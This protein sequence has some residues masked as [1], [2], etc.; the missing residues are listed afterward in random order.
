[1]T[2]YNSRHSVQFVAIFLTI[3]TI[4]RIIK[5]VPT[6]PP[7]LYYMIWG[8][9]AVYILMH[10]YVSCRINYSYL[11]F[12][13]ICVISIIGNDIDPKYN[14]GLRFI[15]FLLIVCSIGPI[16][17][18]D[19][20]Y[21][22]RQKCFH[23]VLMGMTIISVIS[24]LIYC[25]LP[26]LMLTERGNLYGGITI[27]SMQMGP[28]AGLSTVYMIHMILNRHKGQGNKKL[29]FYWVCLVLSLFSCILAGSRSAILAMIV[30]VSIYIWRYYRN[31]ILQFIKIIVCFV[32]IMAISTPLWW[33][34]T[35]TVQAKMELSEKKGGFITSRS[36]A[37]EARLNEFV[38][39]P[40]I[41]CGFATVVGSF[42]ERGNE[43]MV[44]PGNGWLFVLSTT[45]IVTFVIFLV[46]YIHYLFFLLK[47]ST[48]ESILLGS[49]LIFWGIHINAEAYTLSSGTF[50][51]YFLW[52]SLGY[53]YS[54]INKC[55]L[56]KLAY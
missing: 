20:L 17:D 19:W 31:N 33:T 35:K 39:S 7:A 37:W 47:M 9:S 21:L 43:G 27:H 16:F 4:L 29:I 28:I 13:Y 40:L 24:F 38:D 8:I 30:A 44:E 52:L 22:L 1:M 36:S 48:D 55:K 50:L 32:S 54:Y 41:G 26:T 46:S 53:A 2:N 12:I 25:I 11:L 34:Y 42:S 3:F 10:A 14:I 15:G 23:F 51:F 5:F 49:G 6:M 45:G 18:N 56:P